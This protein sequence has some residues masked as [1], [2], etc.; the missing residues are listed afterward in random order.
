MRFVVQ[1]GLAATLAWGLDNMNLPFLAAKIRPGQTVYDVGAN[2]G[3]MALF[4]SRMAGPSGRVI[5][6]EPAPGNV[7]VMRRNLELNSISNVEAHELALDRQPGVRKLAFDPGRHTMGVFPEASVKMGGWEETIEVRC[8]SVDHLISLGPP[9]PDVLKID[10]EGAAADVIAGAEH[11]L[12]RSRP[13]IYL[14]L[15]ALSRSDPELELLGRLRSEWNYKITDITGGL[16][17]E[18]GIDWGAAVWCEQS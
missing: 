16:D 11:L 15:H 6:F 12:N 1:P 7:A 17:R 5:A 3:Q 9:P 13:S 10:V 8:E 2:C 14:E 4:F 18:P